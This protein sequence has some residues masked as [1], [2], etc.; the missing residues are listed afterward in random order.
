[1]TEEQHEHDET[2]ECTGCTLTTQTNGGT[3]QPVT[4]GA[5]SVPGAFNEALNPTAQLATFMFTFGAEA[6][7]CNP[8]TCA[9]QRPCKVKNPALSFV[10][11]VN[12][13]LYVQSYSGPIS[14]PR[15][16]FTVTAGQ[17]MIENLTGPGGAGGH[18][19]DNPYVIE[20]PCGGTPISWRIRFECYDPSVGSTNGQ[21]VTV[22]VACTGCEQ[23]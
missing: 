11:A 5:G 15:Q 3:P 14:P 9:P 1:M 22:T 10:P 2:C 7:A 4:G 21:E 23:R 18:T 16:V 17:A 19:E 13:T 20:T 12:G 8:D 6:G